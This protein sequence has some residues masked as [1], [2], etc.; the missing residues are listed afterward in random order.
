[1]EKAFPVHGSGMWPKSNREPGRKD[2][3]PRKS[4]GGLKG[5]CFK[6]NR[7]KY[8]KR[9]CPGESNGIDE[10]AVFAVGENRFNEWLVDSGARRI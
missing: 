10:D 6:C 4:E 3:G 9:N 1:M 8:M 2:Y 7:V 5:M